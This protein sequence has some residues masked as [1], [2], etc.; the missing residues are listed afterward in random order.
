MLEYFVLVVR[1]NTKFEI[2]SIEVV[3]KFI[4]QGKNILNKYYLT[5]LVADNLAAI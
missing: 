3:I 1:L 4:N 2:S 5:N